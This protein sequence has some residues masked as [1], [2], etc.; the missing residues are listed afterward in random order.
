[1]HPAHIPQQ[2]VNEKDHP[3]HLER[4]FERRWALALLERVVGRLEAESARSGKAALFDRL[5]ATL[6]GDPDAS[7]YAAI[8]RE[9]GTT[10]GAI[11]A[12]AAR[13]RRRY[14]EILCE[15]I[16]RT[17]DDPAGVEEEIRDLFAALGG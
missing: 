2:A 7:R 13:L 6:T 11:K 9:L 5:K 4:L 12:A 8:A 17:V 14:R 15:E 1:M 10:E 3:G 16:A